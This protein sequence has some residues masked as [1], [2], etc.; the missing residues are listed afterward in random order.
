VEDFIEFSN[1]QIEDVSLPHY[2]KNSLL[3]R[4]SLLFSWQDTRKAHILQSIHR[5]DM[6]LKKIAAVF[7]IDRQSLYF[8]LP[9][10]IEE[11]DKEWYR[12]QLIQRKEIFV[13]YTSSDGLRITLTD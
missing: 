1:H 4:L 11:I 5:A 6:L 7:H 2:E 3:E 12:N 8:M 13:D 9:E 10:E